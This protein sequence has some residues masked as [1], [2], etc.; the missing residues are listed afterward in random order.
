MTIVK[1]VRTNIT[2]LTAKKQDAQ[3][4]FSP[5][6]P[7]AAH[8]ENKHERRP[9]KKTK[10]QSKHYQKRLTAQEEIKIAACCIG[11]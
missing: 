9:P 8:L 4:E 1:I 11:I 6:L 7:Q 2:F 3:I 10:S 5:T